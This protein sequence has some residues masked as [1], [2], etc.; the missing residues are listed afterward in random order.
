M[1]KATT[2]FLNIVLIM[3]QSFITYALKNALTRK[4]IQIIDSDGDEHEKSCNQK[5]NSAS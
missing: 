2:R 3:E 5:F 4:E 1:K